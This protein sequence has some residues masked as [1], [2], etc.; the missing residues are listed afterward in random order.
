MTL[1][2]D[3]RLPY[4]SS[5][6]GAHPSHAPHRSLSSAP[7]DFSGASGWGSFGGS[8]EPQ[9]HKEDKVLGYTPEQLFGVVA[10]VARYQEFVPWCLRSE[11][12]W[13]RGNVMEAEL[14]IGFQLLKE[15]Y[16]SRVT[17]DKPHTV[18]STV[19]NSLLFDFLNCHWEFRPGPVPQSCHL[20]FS[21]EF[22]FKSSLYRQVSD[23][24]FNEV[25]CCLV[26]SFE[27]RCAAIHGPARRLENLQRA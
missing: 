18:V 27:Q 19:G 11:V 15:R 8:P 21:V 16:T 5:A 14:E 10:D 1:A 2:F 6:S 26:A 24:F 17:T 22:Q 3:H 13:T 20:Y 25:V 23:L 4:A 7:W 9:S 12:L